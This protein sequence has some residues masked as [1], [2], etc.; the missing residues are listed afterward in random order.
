MGVRRGER[1]EITRSHRVP[2]SPRFRRPA[3]S[4]ALG[5]SLGFTI[6]RSPSEVNNH[7]SKKVIVRVV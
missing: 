7:R 1:E 2:F 5:S 4:F 3:T 6:S